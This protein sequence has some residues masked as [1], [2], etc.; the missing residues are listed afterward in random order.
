LLRTSLAGSEGA[1]PVVAN[2]SSEADLVANATP[3]S[4]PLAQTEAAAQAKG[5]PWHFEAVLDG[6]GGG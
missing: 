3:A 4:G 5:K 6:F 2:V 1:D